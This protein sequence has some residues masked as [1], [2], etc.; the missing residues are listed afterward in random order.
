MFFLG[1]P[2]SSE[3]VGHEREH[4]DVEGEEEREHEQAENA[5][6]AAEESKRGAGPPES[7]IQGQEEGHGQDDRHQ[8]EAKAHN[9]D[10]YP[11]R[12]SLYR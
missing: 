1:G 8:N 7:P 12:E 5:Q 4:R 10:R 11:L 3:E 9:V 2:G 6:N